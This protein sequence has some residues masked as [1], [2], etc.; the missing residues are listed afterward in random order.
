MKRYGYVAVLVGLCALLPIGGAIATWQYAGLQALDAQTDIAFQ[1]NTFTFWQ[2][3]ETLPNEEGESHVTLINNLLN[4]VDENGTLVGLNNPDSAISQ[5]L[6]N[7]LNGGLWGMFN[8]TDYYGSMD[9]SILDEQVDMEGL[10]N[11]DTLGLDFIVQVVD[12]LTYYIFTTSVD[13]GTS[14]APNIAL[15][16]EI[17]P[18]YRSIAKRATTSSKFEMVSTAVGHAP[19]MY[20][21]QLSGWGILHDQTVPSFD[22]KQ[23]TSCEDEPIGTTRDN[24][25][26]T[27][28]GD[29]PSATVDDETSAMYFQMR[30]EGDRTI[31]SENM[32]AEFTVTD[33]QGSVVAVSEQ[34]TVDMRLFVQVTFTATAGETY[35][36]QVTGASYI[37]FTI[38]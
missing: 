28:V 38:A 12:D 7:R 17:Y 32:Q 20:Y 23:W 31:T 19:S 34:V 1:M 16:E 11:T 2:G 29:T 36:I 8:K 27:F 3:A 21:E 10:F 24:A 25:V 5:N 9:G 6:E 26:W 37:Q 33:A 30:A 22:V 4:G 14:G 13:M 18:I 15:G 35:Y